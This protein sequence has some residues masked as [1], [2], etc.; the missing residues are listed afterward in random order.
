MSTLLLIGHGRMGRLVQSLAP[1]HGFDVVGA[2]DRR[3]AASGDWPSADV[4]IDFSVADAVAATVTRLARQRIPIVIGTTG[5]QPH[6]AA[7][8]STVAAAGIGVV[9]APNFAVG[10]NVFLAV[11]ERLGALMAAQPSFGAWIHE[12]HHAAKKDAPSGTALAIEQRLR[13]QGYTAD[14]PIA[15]TRAGAIPGTH[16]LG[17]DAP[18]ETLTLTHQARDRAAFARGALVAARWVMGRTGWFTM[19]DVLN[20][21]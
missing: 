6:E 12:S 8:R 10:V 21:S 16:T 18:S 9:A 4:A 7:V 14:L 5:W 3:T 2:I 11:V 20:L 15:S 1:E 13:R 19:S 17:F